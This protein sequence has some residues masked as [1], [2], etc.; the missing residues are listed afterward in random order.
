MTIATR[1]PSSATQKPTG[2]SRLG[3]AAVALVLGAGPLAWAW[4]G[5]SSWRG[6]S[7]RLS[8]HWQ[9]TS[10]VILR[11]EHYGKSAYSPVVQYHVGTK[12]FEIEGNGG[13]TG[14]HHPGTIIDV[15]YREENP[16]VARLTEAGDSVPPIVLTALGLLMLSFA[17][18]ALF[19]SR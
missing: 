2:R 1:D 14:S 15:L 18:L 10:G 16:T 11:V 13:G 6:W 8:G 3:C 7:D 19:G 5:N 17:G 4:V 9:H 12:T